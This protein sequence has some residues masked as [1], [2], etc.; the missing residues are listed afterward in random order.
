MN[1]LASDLTAVRAWDFPGSNWNVAAMSTPQADPFCCRTEW[2]LSFY[3]AMGDR[4][5][6]IVRETPGSLVALMELHDARPGLLFGPLESHWFFGSPLL[7]PDAP[8][9]LSD[10]LEDHTPDAGAPAPRFVISGIPQGPSVVNTLFGKL[11]PHYN[12]YRIH[13]KTLCNA[14]LDGGL[15]GFLSRRSAKYRSNLRKQSRRAAMQGVTFERHAPGDQEAAAQVYARMIT[16][17][18]Q[19]WKGVGRCGM[20]EEPSRAYYA[21]MMR[22]LAA[23]ASGRIMFARHEER[24]IGYIFGGL[25]DNIYRGQQFSYVED[26]KSYSIGN[27]LQLE[28]I[29]WLCE[30]G[31]TRYD[32]GP[33]MDYKKHWTENRPQIMTAMIRRKSQQRSRQQSLRL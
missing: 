12:I 18:E 33:L 11:S 31:I 16:V 5:R 32:M 19:S 27:L 4:G 30:E 17:E 1:E 25:A 10:I 20:A 29:R 13:T 21:C 3:E 22:R 9:L 24:D 7:G 26:W 6:L 28:L 2:Q 23:S 8:D 15:D 14:S